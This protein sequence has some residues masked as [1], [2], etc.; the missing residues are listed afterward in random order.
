M[1]SLDFGVAA[2]G[3]GFV[4]FEAV[5]VLVA[6]AAVVAA[7]GFVFFHAKGAWVWFLGFGVDDGVGT[8]FVR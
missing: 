8:V 6:F 1:G 2:W 5:E 3:V 4:V 7:V